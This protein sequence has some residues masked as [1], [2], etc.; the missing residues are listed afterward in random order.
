MSYLYIKRMPQEKLNMTNVLQIEISLSGFKSG[1]IVSLE[2]HTHTVI[3]LLAKDN[4]NVAFL[5]CLL[6]WRCF[7]LEFCPLSKD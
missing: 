7:T 5:F 3:F 2:T 6:V 4:K 1:A